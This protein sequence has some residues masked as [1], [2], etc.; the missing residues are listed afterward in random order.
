KTVAAMAQIAQEKLGD[1]P[2]ALAL[3]E[4]ALDLDAARLEAFERIVRI[5]TEQRDWVRL[6]EAYRRMIMRAL[7][8]GDAKL[9]HALYHQ[10]GLISRDRLG[11]S[12]RA[13]G[14]FRAAAELVPEDKEV[15]TI[16]RELLALSGQVDSAIAVTLGRVQKD[17]MSAE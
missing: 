15:Q 4:E 2:S 16:L 9:Q 5:W 1:I 11:D 10:A 8:K 14:Y 13:L 12:K 3:N 17:P 7:G 6:E